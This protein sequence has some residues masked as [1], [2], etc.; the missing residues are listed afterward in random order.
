MSA[1]APA[2][3]LLTKLYVPP[4]RPGVVARPRLTQRLNEGL[5]QPLTLISAP[6]GFGKTTLAAEW[7]AQCGRPVAWL[8]LDER[9]GDPATF[10]TY[11]VAAL[12]T[13]APG[14]GK[15]VTALLES[16][17]PPPPEAIL[18][19]LVN[20][21]TAVPDEVVLVLD[22]YHAL[23]SVPADEALAFLL[24]HLPPP[25]HVIIVTR[26][27]PNLPLA[28]LRAGG[29]LT[30]VRE[31]DLR[32]SAGEAG[33][34]LKRA[35]GLD[36][37]A[38]DIEALEHRTEGWIA[39]LQMAAISLQGI[40]DATAFIRSFTGS[41][42]F[43]LDYLLEEVLD[44]QSPEVQI[45]LLQTAI[46]D[47]LCGPLCDA[48][49]CSP[50]GAGDST[51]RVIERANLFIVPLDTERR[52]YRY[53]RLFRDLLR[54]RLGQGLS[55]GAT[56]AL[57]LRASEW[58]EHNGQLLEAFRHATAAGDV[59]R[60]ARLIDSEG[61]DLHRR[62]V[63]VPILDWLASLP[64]AVVEARPQLLVRSATLSLMAMR[65]AGVEEK[66]QAA[67][68][69]LEGVEP[70]E[71]QRDLIGQIACARATLAF[72]RYDIATMA[73]Q[74][75]RAQEYLS[76]DNLPFRFTAAWAATYAHL[77]AGDRGAAARACRECVELS[78]RS[79]HEFSRMLAADA[80]GNLQKLDN[81][82]HQA[83]ASFRRVLELA[84]EHP[85]PNMEE[86]HLGLGGIF[87]EW[88]ELDAAEQEGEESRQ[89]ARFYDRAI[90]RSIAVDVFRARLALA[91]GDVEGAAAMLAEAQRVALDN[92][93][94]LRLPE[95]AAA[96]VAT[97]IRK[98][99][100]AA[101]ACIAEQHELP[102]SRARVLIAQGEPAAAL[103]I[104]EPYGRGM[105][106]RGWADERLRALVLQ[107]VAQH[108]AGDASAAARSLGEAL[109]LA[110]PGGF[111]RLF[112][113]EGPPMAELLAAA[114]QHIRP[115]YV[116]RLLAAFQLEPKASRRPSSASDASSG[117]E[118]LS[119]RE[120][121]VLR[122]IADGLSNQEIG[123]RL[124]LA[125]DTVKGHNRRIFE[126]LGVQRRTE[127]VARAREFGLL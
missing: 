76:P 114:A 47:R 98:G 7:A 58:Y 80:L 72:T 104:L 124:F 1:R 81:Q 96:Q 79:G 33:E 60:A 95:I 100:V 39:G 32:F 70:D 4:S 25:L 94:A 49:L 83:A 67:E 65:T 12:Q 82:L 85:L 18:T 42:R 21:I 59:E 113:D 73:A 111:I 23:D 27:D 15:G 51:L 108:L 17:Q 45:F 63:L 117:A 31:A 37:P 24:E 101:A 102:L 77:F 34:F 44:R 115:G 36:L 106:A 116:G 3:L 48:V 16:P 6:A 52:W 103:A 109:A 22:D 28:R 127:A 112:V 123:R 38:D 126:K 62:S 53:H 84:G 57:H 88:N 86:V 14:I 90:D 74:A 66:L 40:P 105:E 61:M 5:H 78:E 110:E 50:D 120:I 20:E 30:E 92:A 99:D 46:L 9:D 89:L 54:Q 71:E 119:P 35:T 8:S 11:I 10:L 56:A 93:F 68:R 19:V 107:T 121:E 41:N 122:L 29:R 97:L 13:I 26:E 87:Y 75:R 2:P 55:P 69:V 125:L 118:P 64:S 43:V 91:G